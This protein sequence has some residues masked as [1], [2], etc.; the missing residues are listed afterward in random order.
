MTDPGT[1]GGGGTTGGGTAAHRGEWDWSWLWVIGAFLLAVVIGVLLANLKS[2]N[3][4][5]ILNLLVG[6]GIVY[7]AVSL[8]FSAKSGEKE[9]GGGHMFF[10]L[11]LLFIGATMILN[12]VC[13]PSWLKEYQQGVSIYKIQAQPKP[14]L[15]EVSAPVPPPDIAWVNVEMPIDAQEPV[16]VQIEMTKDQAKQGFPVLKPVLDARGK[17]T[18]WYGVGPTESKTDDL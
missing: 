6:F 3:W 12:S 5:G 8:I 18:G 17:I 10:A 9:F 4:S 15:G 1:G 2:Q 7:F 13:P 11:V 14:H 16:F